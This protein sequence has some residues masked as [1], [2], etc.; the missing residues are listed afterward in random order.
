MDFPLNSR[1]VLEVHAKRSKR[2]YMAGGLYDSRDYFTPAQG[3]RNKI[4]LTA[5][6]VIKGSV[7]MI[8]APSSIDPGRTA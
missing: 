4:E 7:R 8:V 1:K 6:V 5:S 3:A 2:L